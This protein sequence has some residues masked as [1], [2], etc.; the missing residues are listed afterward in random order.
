[1]NL[2]IHREI[3][4]GSMRETQPINYHL[5]LISW[6]LPIFS[7]DNKNKQSQ[8]LGR[9]ADKT[10]N[11]DPCEQL[12]DSHSDNRGENEGA[13]NVVDGPNELDQPCFISTLDSGNRF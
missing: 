10:T 9:E 13:C 5:N 11:E 6:S 4:L 12:N 8:H 1:M 7:N 3:P 2:E